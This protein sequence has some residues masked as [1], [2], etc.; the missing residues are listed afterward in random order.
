MKVIIQ[1]IK[2]GSLKYNK[3]VKIIKETLMIILLNIFIIDN[4]NLKI[5]TKPKIIGISYGNNI[6]QKQLKIN[7][8]TAILIGKVDEYY[9]FGPD[10][11]DFEFK[12]KN[13]DILSRER[14]NGY[15]LWKPYFILKTLKEKLKE[16]D[17]LIYTDA[18]I[19][20]MNS[21]KKIIDFLKEKNAEMWAFQLNY[22][23]DLLTI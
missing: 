22:L 20:Y 12:K 2:K 5:S 18:G 7:K 23:S 4:V 16:G 3:Y 21:T 14:G 1:Y 13:Q 9:S 17:Y 19:L 8:K 6:F 11:I 10:D 15:W